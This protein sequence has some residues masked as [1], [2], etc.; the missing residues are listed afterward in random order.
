MR[1]KIIKIRRRAHPTGCLAIGRQSKQYRQ[2][3]QRASLLL[4][5]SKQNQDNLLAY[6]LKLQW[7]NSEVEDLHCWPKHEIRFQR[8][9]VYIL[10]LPCHCSSPTPLSDGHEGEKCREPLCRSVYLHHLLKQADRTNPWAQKSADRN[11]L[12]VTPA[13]LH[14]AL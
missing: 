12:S 7:D 5:H 1:P 13:G 3:R 8:R 2:L 9:Q 11:R 14:F 10:E 4:V 6:N